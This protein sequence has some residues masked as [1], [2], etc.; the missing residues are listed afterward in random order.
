[1]KRFLD[2]ELGDGNNKPGDEQ[3]S[4]WQ[5]HKT[6]HMDPMMAIGD[7]D[8]LSPRRWNVGKARGNAEVKLTPSNGEASLTADRIFGLSSVL[9]LTL[10]T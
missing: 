5:S 10:A 7:N 3:P 6:L 2:D 1:M 9:L 8:L 4:K